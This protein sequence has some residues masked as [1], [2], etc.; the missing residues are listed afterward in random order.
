[1]S[2]M[3]YRIEL[4][5]PTVASWDTEVG[6][7]IYNALY[8]HHP[9]WFKAVQT[10][11]APD[12]RVKIVAELQSHPFT[13]KQLAEQEAA[14]IYAFIRDAAHDPRLKIEL[15]GNLNR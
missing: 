11:T 8:D 7:F 1:M 15:R 13:Q 6:R 10:Q 3:S 14:A 5:L 4:A 9:D 12:R 2:D